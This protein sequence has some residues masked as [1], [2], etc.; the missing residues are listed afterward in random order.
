MGKL[1]RRNDATIPLCRWLDDTRAGGLRKVDGADP[2][3]FSALLLSLL[4][5]SSSTP[6][7]DRLSHVIASRTH[8]DHNHIQFLSRLSDIDPDLER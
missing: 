1:A 2:G 8:S 7:S 6:P 4:R 3:A 5:Y